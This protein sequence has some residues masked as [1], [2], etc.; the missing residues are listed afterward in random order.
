MRRQ[1]STLLIIVVCLLAVGLATASRPRA[2]HLAPRAGATATDRLT[3]HVDDLTVSGAVLSRIAAA[4][5]FSPIKTYG[6][7]R[8]APVLATAAGSRLAA[9]L[10]RRGERPPRSCLFRVLRI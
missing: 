6:T 7:G 9:T 8:P 4:S 1:R 10:A 5:A 3:S 2:A